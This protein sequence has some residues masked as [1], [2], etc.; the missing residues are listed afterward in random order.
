MFLCKSPS[1]P[2]VISFGL[3]VLVVSFA[4]GTRFA[5]GP[6]RCSGRTG[7]EKKFQ[8]ILRQHVQ[9]EERLGFQGVYIT[10]RVTGKG[11]HLEEGETAVDAQ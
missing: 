4:S 2:I 6:G 10:V 5:W 8:L 9:Y 7:A 3:K 11:G 1:V